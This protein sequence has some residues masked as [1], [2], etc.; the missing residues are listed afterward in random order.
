M[1]GLSNIFLLTLI[2]L[3]VSACGQFQ[4]GPVS[5]PTSLPPS[6]SPSNTPIPP[7]I[8]L[9]TETLMTPSPTSF[10]TIDWLTTASTRTEL[11]FAFPGH[12]EGSAPLTF[13]EGEFVKGPDQPIGFTFQIKLSGSPDVLFNNWGAKD[14]G[15]V[16]IFAFTPE[17]VTDGPNVAI[18][19]I[20][21]TTR[22]AQG[23]GVTAQV[24][25]IQRYNDVMEVMWFAPTEQV[26]TLQPVLQGVLESIEI[27]HKY[28]DRA[29]G[30]QTMYV[31]DWLAPQAPWQ[32]QGLWFRSADVRTGMVIFI[33]NEIADPIQLLESWSV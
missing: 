1:K 29:N 17:T 15:I 33:I 24:A 3:V 18:A 9:P 8:A 19:R 21:T 6:P 20:D 7:T 23:N 27:W 22:I 14:V 28:A 2:S 32:N 16:G 11:S 4:A 30:L 26:E 25:Y 13:G 31:H 12:W 5:T 10:T